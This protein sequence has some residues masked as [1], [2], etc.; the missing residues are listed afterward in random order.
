MVA[1]L[2][3]LG[4][5]TFLTP[6]RTTPSVLIYSFVPFLLWAAVRFGSMGVSTSM[7]VIS[8]LSIW[9]A[10]YGHGP[11]SGLEPYRTILSLQL[12]LMFAAIPFMV[13]AAL[14]EERGQ[15]QEVLR[16]SEDRMRLAQS[17]ARIGTFE[18]NIRTGVNTWTP[19]LEA[20]Y[21]LPPGGFGGTQ[22]AFE[23]L[24]HPDDRAR[25]IDLDN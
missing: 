14:A 17:T 12:F 5:F 24:V 19:E 25:V 6:W 23:N 1:A 4:Y 10:I 15:D 3:L 7:I 11:F 13:L 22:T 20:L 16:K 2:V 9:G 21:G 18:W 8:F